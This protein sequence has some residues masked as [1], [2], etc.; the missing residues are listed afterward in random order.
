MSR[1]LALKLVESGQMSVARAAKVAGLPLEEFIELLGRHGV[2]AVDYPPEE[3][4]EELTAASR[5]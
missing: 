2:P 1:A 5:P 3:L 4:E